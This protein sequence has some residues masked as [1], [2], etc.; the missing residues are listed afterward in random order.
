MSS[1][2]LG[3]IGAGWAAQK[4]LE[5]IQAINGL[6]AAG[7]TS[8]TRTKAEQL[9]ATFGIKS[10]ADD[11]PSLIKEV[12]PDALMVLVNE[13]Q[14]VQV[15]SQVMPYGLPL[16]IEKPAGLT[17]EENLKLVAL[18]R[19]HAVPTMVG[20]NRRYYSIF[21]KGLRII[22]DHGPL[23]G[24]L[25]E[26][27]ER[28]WRI[29]EGKK[30]SA[31]LMAHWIFA[32]ST[33]TIDLLRFFGGEPSQVTSIAHRRMG[34]A[35]GDQFAAIMELESGAI[36]QYHA[37]WYSPGG[38]RVVLYGQGATV[39]FK[40][41][42]NGRWMDKSFQ[43]Y[44][45]EPDPVDQKFKPG[46]Y[47]QMKAFAEF[48]RKRQVV[49]PMLDLQGAYQTMLLAQQFSAKISFPLKGEEKAK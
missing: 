7:I 29:R 15:L 31:E 9:A 20:F 11:I 6:E 16:F 44:E 21:H 35:R 3:L 49:W 1:L 2:R 43:V 17:P 46:F 26:G 34:E 4:H 12:Q 32:N 42:E 37:H 33:H 38:W 25:V 24:V 23:L 8:R 30:F 47:Q 18:A 22:Q 40:P 19:E 10:C 41:L 48:V 27:H 28:M 36:G 13:D 45:I 14:M 5:V 39:E